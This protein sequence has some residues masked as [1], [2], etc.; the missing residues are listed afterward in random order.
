MGMLLSLGVL[1]VATELLHKS[2]NYEHKS[3]LSVVSVLK[4]IDTPTIYF[5]LGILLAVSCLQSIGLLN[6]LA[7]Y[8]NNTIGN[9][10]VINLVIGLFSAIVDNVPLVAGAMGMYPIDEIGPFSKDGVFWEFLAYCAGTGGSVLII[11]SAGVAVMGILRL[12]LFGIL[13]NILFS[14]HWV[15]LWCT[16]IYFISFNLN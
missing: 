6:D 5:F 7:D 16:C 15:C 4:K 3:L 12:I 1:W 10:Y 14:F 2:K 11:G 8:L 13:K 9:I